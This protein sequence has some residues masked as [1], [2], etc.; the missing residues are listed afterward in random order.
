MG[1]GPPSGFWATRLCWRGRPRAFPLMLPR[2]SSDPCRLPPWLAGVGSGAPTRGGLRLSLQF[3]R[4]AYVI[5]LM[6]VYW[7]TE[8][9]PLAVTSLMPAL[10]FPLLKILDSKQVSSPGRLPA[11]PPWVTLPAPSE[12]PGPRGTPASGAETDRVTAHPHSEW[13]LESAPGLRTWL[14]ARGAQ[15]RPDRP[16]A[17]LQVCV[18]YMKDTNMLFLGGLIM[19]VAVERW[20]LHKR[21][22]LRTLLWV[23]AKPA[24]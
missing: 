4:C 12:L 11:S 10:L 17:V 13:T 8:V 5:I 9:I 20:N 15:G 21:I 24:Q 14:G 3:V 1:P 6:A 22:A 7:C 2:C 16:C 18:Q 19:A 23:G